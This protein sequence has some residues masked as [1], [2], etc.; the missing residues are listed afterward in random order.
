MKTLQTYIKKL[1]IKDEWV[2]Y[3][4]FVFLP[5][6]SITQL[7]LNRNLECSRSFLQC[8]FFCQMEMLNLAGILVFFDNFKL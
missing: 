6:V 5:E 7:P 8:T 2:N 1:K 3:L 4:Y